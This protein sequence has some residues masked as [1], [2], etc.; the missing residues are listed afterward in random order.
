ML[1]YSFTDA[2]VALYTTLFVGL[3]E[4]LAQDGDCY[5]TAVAATFV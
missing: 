5:R 4:G 3:V 1:T 2:T